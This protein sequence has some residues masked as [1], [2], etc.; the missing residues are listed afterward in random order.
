MR[1]G[2]AAK[3]D[4]RRARAERLLADVTD[5]R[6]VPMIWAVFVSGGSQRLQVAAVQMLGQIDGPAASTALA[7]LALLD[8]DG[9]VRR[10]R[11]RP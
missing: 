6:A 8:P 1:D 9:V 2:L 11:P 5:P 10:G 3:D 7:T 4:P